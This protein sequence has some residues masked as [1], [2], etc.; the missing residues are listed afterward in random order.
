MNV[1]LCTHELLPAGKRQGQL[2]PRDTPLP[3]T[4]K[5]NPEIDGC[6][7]IG[8]YNPVGK[9]FKTSALAETGRRL[10]H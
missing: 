3:R 4:L 6:P 1:P 8:S 7:I 2:L 10:G 5:K 9:G